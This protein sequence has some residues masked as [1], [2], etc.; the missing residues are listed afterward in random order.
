MS[1]RS[2]SRRSALIDRIIRVDHAGELGANRIYQG[3]L[4]VL[5]KS[6][7]GPIIKEMHDQEKAHLKKFESLIPRYR[8]RPTALL[9]FWNVA[10]LALGVGSALFGK[11]AAMACT[12]A[13]ESVISEHYNSQIRELIEHDPAEYA[14]LLQTLTKFRDEEIEHHDIGLAHEAEQPSPHQMEEV[15]RCL[16]RTGGQGKH[17]SKGDVNVEIA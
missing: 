8:V 2:L 3:Q 4:F 6:S 17:C 12:V 10:G 16:T 1:L 15:L 11:K 13:V 14:E 5:G 9:P 7:V